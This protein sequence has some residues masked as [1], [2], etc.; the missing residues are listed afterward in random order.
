MKTKTL[1]Y[2]V[3]IPVIILVLLYLIVSLITGSFCP[4]DGWTG[5][6]PPW[7]QV[8]TF[9]RPF[10]YSDLEYISQKY[11]PIS[12]KIKMGIGTIDMWGNPYVAVDLGE[13]PN[14]N[15]DA[16]FSRIKDIGASSVVFVD[17]LAYDK[18][19]DIKKIK[20]TEF[21][22]SAETVT[23]SELKDVVSKAKSKGFFP[24]ILSVNLY[25][26][27]YTLKK[28]LK[29]DTSDTARFIFDS[30]DSKVYDKILLQW[31][32]NIVEI[33][34][35]AQEA[36]VDFLVINPGDSA[37]EY[38]YTD[39][40]EL[41]RRYSLISEKVRTVFFGKVGIWGMLPYV[42]ND[43]FDLSFADFVLVFWDPNGDYLGKN[44]MAKY[45]NDVDS[46]VNGFN[47]WFSLPEWQNFNG[48]E[49]YLYVTIPSYTNSMKEG[50][51]EPAIGENKWTIDY[52][53][54]ALGYEALFRSLYDNPRGIN[55][56]YVFGYWWSDKIYP[57]VKDLR[58]D[59]LHSIRQKDA[60]KVFYK[61]TTVFNK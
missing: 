40:K 15:V 59:L 49:V 10:V 23:P 24:F 18:N 47:E 3:L 39:L 38:H 34:T 1:F 52:K 48:K 57:E 53:E 36:G 44:I 16:T 19:M 45:G 2:V 31:E 4:P 51:I 9:D 60:E 56:V 22:P 11:E 6:H 12:N 35:Q 42:G 55:G 58:N 54:Q 30:G 20:N 14:K 46:F 28:G 8:K 26:P 25:D 17:F 61:W 41:S 21:G 37:L 5:P 32:E 50:W 29:L 43:D 33:A 13:T 7:C 27:F